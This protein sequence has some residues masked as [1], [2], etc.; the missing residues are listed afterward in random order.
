LQG[1]FE[2]KI[3]PRT[4][5]S[6]F[7]NCS[8]WDKTDEGTWS[9]EHKVFIKCPRFPDGKGIETTYLFEYRSAKKQVAKRLGCLSCKCR[10]KDYELVETV[11]VD[12]EGTIITTRTYKER[13]QNETEQ[14]IS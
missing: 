5:L 7:S 12:R 3:L 8:H 9:D 1:E 10:D 11:A 2:L 13:N 6:E 14:T 4:A